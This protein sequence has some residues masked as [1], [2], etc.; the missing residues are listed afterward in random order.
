MA[1]RC[2]MVIRGT[3]IPCVVDFI[4]KIAAAFGAVV[5][6]PALPVVGNVFVCAFVIAAVKAE[7]QRDRII[8]FITVDFCKVKIAVL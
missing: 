1:L 4:S 2:V 3:S 6:M 7:I 5:P 8:F